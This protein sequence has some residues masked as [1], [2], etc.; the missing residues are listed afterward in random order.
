M[1]E[2]LKEY[3]N[4]DVITIIAVSPTT[5]K[6][7]SRQGSYFLKY[8]KSNDIDNIINK[9]QMLHIK[10]FDYIIKNKY[11]SY[12]SIYENIKFTLSTFIENDNIDA[13][14][15][16]M[17]TYIQKICDLHNKSF[18][19][20]DVS[21]D[22]FVETYEFIENKLIDVNNYLE[23]YL[24]IIEKE[25]YKSP[26]EWI[27]IMNYGY[28]KKCM[29][30]SYDYLEKFKKSCE[31]KNS[32]RMVMAYL[33]F[34]YSHILVKNDRI[35]SIENMVSA[36]PIFDIFDMID[37]GYN[38]NFDLSSI[39]EIYNK[40]FPLQEYEKYWLLSLIYIPKVNISIYN[41][42][43]KTKQFIETLEYCNC[44][45]KIDKLLVK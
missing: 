18:F 14:E 9:L 7:K 11:N 6:V 31:D 41:E 24:Q 42:L 28:I 26:F 12:V 29:D 13:K 15:I 4:I 43:E 1:N 37:K 25:D 38:S 40:N 20:L 5:Y 8:V 34:D 32:I 36:P 17:K 30:K 22:F 35:I 10:T 19:T 44:I 45:E 16:K 39:V 27:F 3:Y 33:N 2:I 23:D 21:K